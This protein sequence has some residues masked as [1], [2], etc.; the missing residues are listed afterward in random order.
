LRDRSLRKKGSKQEIFQVAGWI[1]NLNKII[2]RT[3]PLW[4]TLGNLETDSL[5]EKIKNVTINKPI[6]ISGLARSGTTILLEILS[7]HKDLVSQQYKDFPPVFIPHFWNSML[8]MMRAQYSK[9]QERA[10][11]DR[12]KVTSES[13]EAIEEVVWMA[14]FKDLHDPARNNILTKRT[15]NIKFENFYNAHL[16]KLLLLRKGQRYLAKGNYNLTRI[17]YLLKMYPDAKFVIPVRHPVNHIASL[18]KQHRLFCDGCK[19]NSKALKYLQSIG[20]YEFGLDRRPINVGNSS[21]IKNILKLWQQGEEIKGQA[22][23]WSEIH[24]YLNKVLKK[25]KKIAEAVLIV[26]YEDLCSRPQQ[27]LSRIFKHCEIDDKQGI[28]KKYLKRLSLPSYYKIDLSATEINRIWTETK[29]AA[30][31]F[32]YNRGNYAK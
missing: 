12:I 7:Q 28:I 11:K 29:T 4:I 27:V 23:Y 18:V 26:R 6:Y 3:K 2:K 13:P 14:F 19:N 22:K 15:Q 30:V 8:K 24:A 25:D 32:G 21:S 10:H 20:H 5:E 16:K 31:K 9:P 17:E 1:H